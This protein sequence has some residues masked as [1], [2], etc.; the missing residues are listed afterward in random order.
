MSERDTAAEAREAAANAPEDQEGR[1]PEQ[2]QADLRRD[3]ERTRAELGETVEALTQK[4]DVKTQAKEKV[5]EAKTQ[6]REKVE[7]VRTQ[8]QA[9]T[10][11]LQQKLPEQARD[12]PVVPIAA[13]IGVALVALWLIRRR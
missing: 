13:G 5:D 6:A 10:Q 11:E 2:E 8:A 9:K 7:G 12:K 1:S 4:A 3:I